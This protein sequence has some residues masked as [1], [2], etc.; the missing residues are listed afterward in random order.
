MEGYY[1]IIYKATNLINNKVYIGQTIHS[2][3]IRINQHMHNMRINKNR[4]LYNSMNKYGVDNFS[5]KVI[6]VAKNR[7][8][9]NHKEIYWIDYFDSY[10]YKENSN[11]YNL[12]V[13]G[14]SVSG[15]R[16][17]EETKSTMSESRKGRLAGENNPMFGRIKENNPF[18]GKSHSQ[19]TKEKISKANKGRL[20]GDSNPNYNKERSRETKD[21]IS[22]SRKGK[23]NG[24]KHHNSKPVVQLSKD[25]EFVARYKTI[26]ESAKSTKGNRNAISQC[27]K[28][29]QKTSNGYI[30]MYEEE[31]NKVRDDMHEVDKERSQD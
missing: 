1:G 15:Y 25:G 31:Y 19:E 11:G 7:E 6:D 24:E 27:C 28:G 13:G 18:Y 17:T 8:E 20:V 14:D 29:N 22:E 3:N 5:W 16:H 9:L 26:R 12:T 2:L 21:R 4:P 10:F 30:W 23:Y